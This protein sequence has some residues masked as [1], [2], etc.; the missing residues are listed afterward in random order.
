MIGVYLDE[1][2]VSA[3]PN[4]DR[5]REALGRFVDEQLRPHD[6]VASSVIFESGQ[7]G[8]VDFGVSKDDT[9]VA[10]ERHPS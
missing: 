10:D 2:H 1:F 3:G 9:A 4:S 8:A 5:V 6:L 7:P